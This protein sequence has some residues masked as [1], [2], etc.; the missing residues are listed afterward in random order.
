VKSKLGVAFWMVWFS[1]EVYF[2]QS[3]GL[4]RSKRNKNTLSVSL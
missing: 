3:H 4:K 1:L 2:N